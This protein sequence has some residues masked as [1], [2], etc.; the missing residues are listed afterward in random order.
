MSFLRNNKINHIITIVIF[1]I[2]GMCMPKST[3]RLKY[4]EIWNYLR[5]TGLSVIFIFF[6]VFCSLQIIYNIVNMKMV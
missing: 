1:R 5:V 4:E 3:I 6:L 2:S